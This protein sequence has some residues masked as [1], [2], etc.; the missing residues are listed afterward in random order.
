MPDFLYFRA[1]LPALFRGVLPAFPFAAFGDEQLQVFILGL[2]IRVE[3]AHPV[4]I[5]KQRDF[6]GVH[7]FYHGFNVRKL[8]GLDHEKNLHVPA[9]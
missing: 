9:D 2:P 8:H 6:L 1:F 3:P 4:A 7:M 5:A